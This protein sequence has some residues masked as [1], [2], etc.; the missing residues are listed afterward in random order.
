MKTILSSS[1]IHYLKRLSIF[2]IMIALMFMTVGATCSA[3]GGDGGG[4]GTG[5]IDVKATLCGDEWIPVGAAYYTLTPASG[6]AIS[7]TTV[8]AS[9]SV[10]SGTWTLACTSS[11]CLMCFL[12][13]ITPSTTQTLSAGGTTT[14]T[15][16]FEL[17]QGCVG[18]VSAGAGHTV[19]LNN[20]GEVVAVGD[21]TYGQCNVDSWTGIIQVAAG[22][23]SHGGA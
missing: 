6:S 3:P 1:R 5:T 7:G 20:G 11:P 12:K 13:S 21:N 17:Y 16:N 9:F 10:A 14:F 22:A 15:L 19:G 8:P 23:L 18:S 4:E 2:L